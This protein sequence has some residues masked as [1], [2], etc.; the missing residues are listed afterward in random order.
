[1][2]TDPL[3]FLRTDPIVLWTFYWGQG[4][5]MDGEQVGKA[6]VDLDSVADHGSRTETLS[7]PVVDFTEGVVLG[8]DVSAATIGKMLGLVTLA[9]FQVLQGKVDLLSTR[10]NNM[11]T[12]VD[13]ML[14]MLSRTPTGA[15]LERIDVQLAALRTLITDALSAKTDKPK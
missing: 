8:K 12:R 1:M 14:Q 5:A 10:V 13:K 6:G 3:G 11:A 2:D 4:E 15:D 9:D 7:K